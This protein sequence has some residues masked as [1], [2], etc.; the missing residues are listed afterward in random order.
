MA[1]I[2][3]RLRL[4]REALGQTQ[5]RMAERV[6]AACGKGSRASVSNWEQEGRSGR[7]KRNP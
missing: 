4:I 1:S 6:H 5:E 3:E 7:G 2:G